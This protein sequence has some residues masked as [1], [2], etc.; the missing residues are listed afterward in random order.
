MSQ[1]VKTSSVDFNS[2]I[3]DNELSLSSDTKLVNKI[4]QTFSEDQQKWFVANF[5]VYLNYH[6]TKDFPINLDNVYKL[7]GFTQKKNAKRTLENNFTEGEDYKINMFHKEQDKTLLL[8]REKQKS[9]NRGGHNEETIMLNIETF[10]SLCM[11]VKTEKAKE[12]RKYYIKL[13]NIY[14]EIIKE[15][16]EE[17]DNKLKLL[18]EKVE[19]MENA[20]ETEGFTEFNGF[21]YVIKDDSKYGVYKIGFGSDP[22]K[23]LETLNISSSEKSLRI[24]KLYKTKNMKWTEKILHLLLEPFRIKRRNEWFYLKNDDELKYFIHS[25][26]NIT[27]YIEQYIF[28]DYNC[29][30]YY[31]DN[32]NLNI[33]DSHIIKIPKNTLQNRKMKRLE[34]S[35]NKISKYVGVSWNIKTNDWMARLTNKETIFLGNY[36]NEI[37]AAIAYN[38][39]ALFLNKN[40]NDKYILND[41]DNYQPN[42]RDIPNELLIKKYENK[43]SNYNGVYFIKSKQIFEA[44]IQYKKKSYKLYRH[45][46][47]RECAKVYNEQALYFNNNLNTSYKLNIIYNFKTEPINHINNLEMSKVKKYSR[48]TGVSIRNDCNKFR[49]YIKHN[50]KRIDCGT[51]VNEIDAAI[52]YNK[53]AEEL[54]NLETTKFKYPLNDIEN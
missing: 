37:D 45:Q 25:I 41:I 34:T 22:K 44:S 15:E 46:D 11:I 35:E 54:N 53:K 32:T 51:F 2:L 10:K 3:R 23:R 47:D 4:K 40:D 16:I 31:L 13:E 24:I 49:A 30:K 9:D 50:G 8:H 5:Y 18:E 43:T 20:P 1:M 48:F 38:D 6:P 36:E 26:E 21:V 52:A 12:I 7:I 28:I 33:D 14:N 42:P 19:L 39:Y 27:K 29:F 17:K